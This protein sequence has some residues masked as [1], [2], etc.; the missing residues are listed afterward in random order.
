VLNVF[1]MMAMLGGEWVGTES[2]TGV[3]PVRQIVTRSV[4]DAPDVDGIATRRAHEVDVLL[5]NYH[6]ADVPAS[7]AKVML[8][9]RGLPR[10]GVMEEAYLMDASHSN[11]SAVWQRMG[12]PQKPSAA[13]HQELVNAGK[14]ERVAAAHPLLAK[15]GVA[16][17]RFLLARQGVTLVR[18]SWN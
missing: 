3:M 15:D 9:V 8:E 13:Q 4:T 10:A 14:L 5:W 7:P 2:S 11:A 17:L 1:R 16:R 12:S 18:L 6:D